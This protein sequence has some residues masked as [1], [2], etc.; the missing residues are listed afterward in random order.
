MTAFLMADQR[1]GFTQF[2]GRVVFKDVRGL[3]PPSDAQA[4]SFQ[5]PVAPRVSAPL[6]VW[7]REVLVENVLKLFHDVV[8]VDGDQAAVLLQR[9]FKNTLKTS[10][11][12]KI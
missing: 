4:E 2:K 3:R 1:H 12:A 11:N 5:R 7:L 10:N 8:H 9:L 6:P